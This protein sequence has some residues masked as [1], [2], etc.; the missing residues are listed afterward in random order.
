[1][2][3]IMWEKKKEE[4]VLYIY[5]LISHFLFLILSNEYSNYR[6]RHWRCFTNSHNISLIGFCFCFFVVVFA[7]IEEE[8]SLFGSLCTCINQN[9]KIIPSIPEVIGNHYFC[10]A[11]PT[12]AFFPIITMIRCGTVSPVKDQIL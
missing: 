1:M 5:L 2:D 4:D 3:V 8:Y 6:C 10:D 9:D 7:A 11:A 12:R